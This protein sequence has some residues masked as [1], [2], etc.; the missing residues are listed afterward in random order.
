MK[1]YKLVINGVEVTSP[2]VKIGVSVTK[3]YAQ[4]TKYGNNPSRIT[5]LT[6]LR[7]AIQKANDSCHVDSRYTTMKAADVVKCFGDDI[8]RFPKT[9]IV[10]PSKVIKTNR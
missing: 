1:S 9:A 3:V 6:I 4:I 5:E 10:I 2:N 8:K 7:N